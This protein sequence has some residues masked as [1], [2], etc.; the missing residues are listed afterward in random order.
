MDIPNIVKHEESIVVVESVAGSEPHE[1]PRLVVD[2]NLEYDLHIHGNIVPQEVFPL[3]VAHFSPVLHVPACLHI[4]L[5]PYSGRRF[6][7]VRVVFH[8][9]GQLLRSVHKKTSSGRASESQSLTASLAE[10]AISTAR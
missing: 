10:V 5:L 3:A 1:E 7:A 6:V 2:L 8:F 9:Q 4:A